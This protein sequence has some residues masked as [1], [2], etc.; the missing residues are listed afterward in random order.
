MEDEKEDKPKKVRLIWK[1][2]LALILLTSYGV[3]I[4]YIVIPINKFLNQ[5]VATSVTIL[6]ASEKRPIPFPGLQVCNFNYGANIRNFELYYVDT[7][8]KSSPAAIPAPMNF[9]VTPMGLFNDYGYDNFNC[10]EINNNNE[11]G[12]NLMIS[13]K[14]QRLILVVRIPKPTGFEALNTDCFP[15]VCD[16]ELFDNATIRDI[17]PR[18]DAMGIS[19]SAFA[20][21]GKR[22]TEI[23]DDMT[24]L[25]SG[26]YSQVSLTYF[27]TFR[28][29]TLEPEENYTIRTSSVRYV[30][31]SYAINFTADGDSFEMDEVVF[32]EIN[33]GELAFTEVNETKPYEAFN[34]FGDATAIVGFFTGFG[35]FGGPTFLPLIMENAANPRWSSFFYTTA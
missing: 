29:E 32:A 7:T 21:N 9:T 25:T 13:S 12:K 16:A 2:L 3:S 28:F 4:A 26:A 6:S 27:R 31:N 34:A 23:L 18:N 33:F 19:L 30:P 35:F 22:R 24:Y 1:I 5:D 15:N 8:N 11:S 10:Y 17:D 14:R 20:P